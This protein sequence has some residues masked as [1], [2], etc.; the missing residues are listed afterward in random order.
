MSDDKRTAE[1]WGRLAVSLP[2][3]RLLPGMRTVDRTGQAARVVGP[4]G[5]AT[6]ESVGGCVRLMQSSPIDPD[7]PA[8]GGCLLGLLS[9]ECYRVMTGIEEDEAWA[10]WDGEWHD[11]PTLGR[12]C[13][14]AAEAL[15]RWPNGG[16]MVAE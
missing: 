12:A 4:S 7:D 16:R 15:G 3:W 1:E 13:I 6:L 8:T 14:A 2:G 5:A 11:A 10:W 9:P